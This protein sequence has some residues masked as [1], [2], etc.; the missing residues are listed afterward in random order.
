MDSTSTATRERIVAGLALAA[1]ALGLQY[2]VRA[3][4]GLLETPGMCLV[5]A[6]VLSVVLEILGP[7]VLRIGSALARALR[8]VRSRAVVSRLRCT[9]FPDA[10]ETADP[11]PRGGWSRV[12][13]CRR[14]GTYRPA[15]LRVCPGCAR[16]C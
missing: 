12:R 3:P 11:R 6:W 9:P 15:P 8:R 1:G 7:P 10:E 14:C 13:P 2:L 4:D 16:A 5:T